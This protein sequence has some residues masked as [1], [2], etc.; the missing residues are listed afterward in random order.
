MLKQKTRG[1]DQFHSLDLGSGPPTS[2]PMEKVLVS[3]SAENLLG[4]YAR[5]FVK[6]CHNRHP[7]RAKSVGLKQDEV[8]M[9]CEFLLQR[10][11]A[12]VDGSITDHNRLRNLA[13]PSFIQYCLENIGIV[14]KVDRGLM[15]LPVYDANVI[16]LEEAQVISDKIA[17]FEEDL[18]ILFDA[19]PRSIEGNIEVM[20]TALIADYVR[21]QEKISPVSSYISAFLGL[22]LAKENVYASLYRI[23]Y[24]DVEFI[25]SA[26][27]HRVIL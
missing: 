9:Y 27:P 15:M 6:E 21:A 23:V 12:F 8:M 24:D 10:R 19:M 25:R 5:A 7:L 11:V 18:V 17:A 1:T 4:D 13:I 22:K 2:V 14:R 3:I 16:S 26:L 20:S